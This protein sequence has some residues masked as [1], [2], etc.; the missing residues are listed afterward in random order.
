MTEHVT[1]NGVDVA[2]DDIAGD[3]VQ[4][5]KAGHGEDNSYVDASHT[6]PFPT[7]AGV[8]AIGDGRKTVTT[9]GTEVQLSST[10]VPARQVVI[11]ALE[12]NTGAV[13]V[14]AATVVASAGSRRGTPLWERD[15]M[16]IDVI[17]LNQV[18]IDAEVATEGVSF[19][20]IA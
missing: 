6:N 11:T 7:R 15:S 9:P 5:V 8:T 10:S 18:Y 14:G 2:V 12:G 20:Y 19:T 3:K 16:T 13:V 17:D 1:V 4:R